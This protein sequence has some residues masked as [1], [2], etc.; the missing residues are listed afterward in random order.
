M[1]FVRIQ[2]TLAVFFACIA[3]TVS[4]ACAEQT[5]VASFYGAGEPLNDNTAM[6]LPFDSRL[7]E[8][9]SWDYPLGAVLEVTSL[10]TGKSVIVRCTDRG[11]AKR[12]NRIID[13]TAHAFALIDDPRVGLTHVRIRRVK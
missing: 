6:N 5:G 7:M 13:L 8:C 11:P 3:M 10:R 9:A 12:L 1:S 2:L 4:A